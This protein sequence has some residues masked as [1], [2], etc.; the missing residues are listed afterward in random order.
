MLS[1]RRNIARG[2][3]RF[4]AALI[5]MD[6]EAVFDGIAPVADGPTS[7]RASRAASAR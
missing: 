7:E 2:P 1:W 6:L 3:V 4:I 5:A